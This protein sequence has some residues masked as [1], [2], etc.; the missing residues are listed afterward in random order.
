MEKWLAD[1]PDHPGAAGRQWLK[2]LYQENKL[3][4]GE[5]VIGGRTVE[6]ER[7]GM[8][9]LNVY[10]E[11]DTVIHPLSSKALRGKVGSN[12][13]TEMP[14]AGGHIG[15]LVARSKKLP[16]GVADWLSKH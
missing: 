6:L 14:L 5:L 16:K 12:D 9:I 13:Y 10:S 4:R 15:V 1:R 7:I 3:V 2:E 8:P 11:T